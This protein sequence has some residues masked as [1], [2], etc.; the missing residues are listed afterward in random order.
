[1]YCLYPSSKLLFLIWLTVCELLACQV[2]HPFMMDRLL[3]VDLVLLHLQCASKKIQVFSNIGL[4]KTTISAANF[5]PILTN[6]LS[7]AIS[8]S[9]MT[10]N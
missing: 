4:I 5:T 6:I 8:H 10:H 1:M 2:K 3:G 7:L 9:H